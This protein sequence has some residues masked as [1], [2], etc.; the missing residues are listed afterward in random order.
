MNS[1]DSTNTLSFR[2]ERPAAADGTLDD[3]YAELRWRCQ[4]MGHVR[5]AVIF[6]T[7]RRATVVFDSDAGAALA[8]AHLD[9]TRLPSGT[10]VQALAVA[11]R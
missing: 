1:A 7:H 4:R 8:R 11:V 3:D 5:S 10:I 6:K 2:L 9:G